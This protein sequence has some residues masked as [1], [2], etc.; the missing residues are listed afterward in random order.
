MPRNAAN[1]NPWGLTTAQRARRGKYIGGSDA[2]SIIAGGAEWVRLWELKTGRAEPEDL[3]SNLRV[4]MGLFTEL[5]NKWWY[6]AQTNR[7]VE[8]YQEFQRHPEIAYLGCT[9]DGITR[10]SRDKRAAWQAKHVGRSGEAME[11]R[12]TAQGTHEALCCGYD[13]YV[14]S[15]F[16]GN[17]KWELH[18]VEV[19]PLFAL[20]YLQKCHEF[21]S[22]VERDR[23]PP[24]VDPLA[25]PPPQ[26]LR[27]IHLEDLNRDHWPNW[28]SPM[29]HEIEAF[30]GTKRAADLH[31]LTR[32][33]IKSLLPDD[34]GEV[35]RGL[36]RLQRTKAGIR[37]SLGKADDE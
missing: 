8:R 4:M 24:E 25:V 17:A 15:V 31:A 7:A 34:V 33:H 13:W 21:W 18:E 30:A 3:S 9:L 27:T 11:L 28:G 16:I 37:M 6:E 2:G 14:L 26:R 23:R 36:F 5:G 35:T 29:A 32:E 22:Y 10:T 20:E 19:D 1:D 12:Y